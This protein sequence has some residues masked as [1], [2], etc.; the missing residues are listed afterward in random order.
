MLWEFLAKASS[1]YSLPLAALSSLTDPFSSSFTNR[2]KW[3]PLYQRFIL[4]V[5]PDLISLDLQIPNVFVNILW[6]KMRGV[7][8][9]QLL[10]R[11]PHHS[12]ARIAMNRRPT[13][14]GGVAYHLANCAVRRHQ[15]HFNISLYMN[16]CP[17]ATQC[18]YEGNIHIIY[19]TRGEH[20]LENVLADQ[21]PPPGVCV[22]LA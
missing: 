12:A 9:F 14:P 20:G 19:S 10:S 2:P 4:L 8:E 16:L 17:G 7:S 13:A 22:G 11:T 6:S 3:R 21:R 15:H 18:C 5:I 1:S